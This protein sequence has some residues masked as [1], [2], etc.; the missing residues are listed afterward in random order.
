MRKATA[1]LLFGSLAASCTGGTI[2]EFLTG[3]EVQELEANLTASV[4]SQNAATAYAYAIARPTKGQDNAMLNYLESSFQE[5]GYR[6][7][8]LMRSI[9]LSDTY[10]T[11]GPESSTLK[12]TSVT[13]K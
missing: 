8:D 3:Y 12:L 7:P 1:A 10:I 5:R 9:A 4:E 2:T 13:T 6:V 11:A